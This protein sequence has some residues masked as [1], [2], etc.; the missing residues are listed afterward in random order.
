VLSTG[1]RHK[2]NLF[3]AVDACFRLKR[4]DVSS[5]QKD[6]GLA[7]GLSYFVPDEPF[8]EYI[9]TVGDQEEV[10]IDL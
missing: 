1:Y 4:R 7:T 3:L 10:R 2:Y 9:A 5:P 8:R 6:P